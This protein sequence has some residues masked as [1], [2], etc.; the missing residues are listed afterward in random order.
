MHAIATYL[1]CFMRSKDGAIIV[2]FALMFP[3]L[4]GFV[5][6]AVEV[7]S[8]RSKTIEL[9]NLADASAYSG[10][11]Y[12]SQTDP[13]DY[14]IFDGKLQS[15]GAV[16]GLISLLSRTAGIPEEQV[17][18]NCN[19]NVIS[20]FTRYV[21]F[22]TPPFSGSNAGLSD[23]LEVQIVEARPRYFSR[24]YD[25]AEVK[26][27]G[28]AVSVFGGSTAVGEACILTLSGSGTAIKVGGSV[29]ATFNGCSI[30]SNST[31]NNSFDMVGAKV[32]V[33]AACLDL[34][35]GYSDPN[36]DLQ[37]ILECGERG[38]VNSFKL[39]DPY[40][41]LSPPDINSC[42][43]AST[44]QLETDFYISDPNKSCVYFSSGLKI[45]AADET[46]NLGAG[47]YVINGPLEITSNPT[48]SGNDITFYLTG[49][50]A[51]LKITGTPNVSLQAPTSGEYSGI[52]FASNSTATTTNSFRGNA[53][54][55]LEGAFYFPTHEIDFSGSTS[56]TSTCI[57]LVSNTLTISGNNTTLYQNCAG[58]TTASGGTPTGAQIIQTNFSV[59]LVE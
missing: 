34:V 13:A 47:T 5:A 11:V 43:Q 28:R 21:L 41:G 55:E 27:V 10:G 6:L 1:S 31:S 18:E 37:L 48:I 22:C 58:S 59:S 15:N 39:V 32:T 45:G 40:S 53:G 29:D 51:F 16:Q 54:M 14:A 24:I 8:W 26:L 46:I 44:N 9:Q 50:D 20:N 12:L 49:P 38:R 17:L 2:P 57:Q 33:T 25:S 36:N 42:E 4:I 23:F 35:G 19:G 30:A 56:A 52:L 3:V 7:G